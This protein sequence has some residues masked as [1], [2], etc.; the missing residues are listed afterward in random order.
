MF[1]VG[2]LLGIRIAPFHGNVA[3]RIGID[4]YIK[5]AVAAELW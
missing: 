3:I 2:N 5:R 4:E 1:A